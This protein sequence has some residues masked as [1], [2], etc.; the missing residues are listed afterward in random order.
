MSKA[1]YA[2]TLQTSQSWA[3]E[4]WGIP[5]VCWPVSPVSE[6]APDSDRPSLKLKWKIVEEKT[7]NIDLWHKWAHADIQRSEKRAASTVR[8]A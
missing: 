8:G 3:D 4:D 2:S 1:G 6:W 5:E 7:P